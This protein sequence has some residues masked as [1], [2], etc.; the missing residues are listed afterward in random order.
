[1]RVRRIREVVAAVVMSLAM[2]G[3]TASPGLAVGNMHSAPS[4][5][6]NP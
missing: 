3:L 5:A 6:G 2:L 4:E 1:M